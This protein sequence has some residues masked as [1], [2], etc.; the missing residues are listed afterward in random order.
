MTKI[1][2]LIYGMM[3]ACII[4]CG[5][6][7]SGSHN[8][9]HGSVNLGS[10]SGFVIL[11]KAGIDTVPTSTITGNIGV[12][13]IDSTGLTGFDLSVDASNT[14]ATSSQLVGKAYASDY[15]PPTPSN[16][17]TAVSDMETAYTDAAGRAADVTELGAGDISGL[18]LKPGTYKWGTG[19]LINTDVTLE[20]SSSDTW[21]FQVAGN[22]T[23][24]AATKVVLAGGALAKNVYWQSFGAVAL[25]TTAHMEGVV[26]SYTEITLSTGATINGR[27]LSQTAVTLDGSTVT[28]P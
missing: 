6:N 3:L 28:H 19:L 9:N 8:S 4:S 5:P 21:I 2:I 17:T 24:A 12:S 16:M 10:A 7:S 18:T 23:Q 22:I 20:G 14:F 13:P 25:D 11:A 26:L 27:L 15:S 1:T